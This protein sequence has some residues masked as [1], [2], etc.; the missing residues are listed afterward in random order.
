MSAGDCGLRRG[1]PSK[2]ELSKTGEVAHREGGKALDA[3]A[4]LEALHDEL[5]EGERPRREGPGAR[6]VVTP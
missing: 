2:D 6:E 5:R 1:S 3:V 4:P